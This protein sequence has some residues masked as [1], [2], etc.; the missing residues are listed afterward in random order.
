MKNNTL[1]QN[2]PIKSSNS[3]SLQMDRLQNQTEQNLKAIRGSFLDFVDDPF[4]VPEKESVRYLPD[5]LGVARKSLSRFAIG[6]GV[7]GKGFFSRPLVA[8][9][10]RLRLNLGAPGLV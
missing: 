2:S 6:L 7:T 9:R 5:G 3:S 10:Y 4:Y 1:N 8:P